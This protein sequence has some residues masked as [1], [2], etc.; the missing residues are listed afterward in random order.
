MHKL[1][2]ATT[3][4]IRTLKAYTF[5]TNLDKP[6]SNI[7]HYEIMSAVRSY[8]PNN[9][10]KFSKYYELVKVCEEFNGIFVVETTNCL[11]CIPSGLE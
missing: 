8:F 1:V 6:T 2:K 7:D 11:Y 3:V 4:S 9:L 10:N 5:T